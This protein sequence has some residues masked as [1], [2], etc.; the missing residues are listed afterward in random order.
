MPCAWPHA[1]LPA[2]VLDSSSGRFVAFLPPHLHLDFFVPLIFFIFW[3]WLCGSL[4][5]VVAIC[6]LAA[7]LQLDTNQL[8]PKNFGGWRVK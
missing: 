1:L 2:N 7:Y 3:A 4:A 6:N 8:G 5:A